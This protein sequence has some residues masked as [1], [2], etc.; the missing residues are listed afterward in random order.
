M[1][2]MLHEVCQWIGDSAVLLVNEPEAQVRRKCAGQHQSRLS[3]WPTLDF[4]KDGNRCNRQESGYRRHISNGCELIHRQ[5]SQTCVD[6]V[7]HLSTRYRVQDSCS[8][9]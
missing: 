2:H 7:A 6:L 4:A 9:V 8:I 5:Q 1:L 3:V